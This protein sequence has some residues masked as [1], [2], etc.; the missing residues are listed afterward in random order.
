MLFIHKNNGYSSAFIRTRIWAYCIFCNA[1][2]FFSSFFF[3]FVEW[4][5]NSQEFHSSMEFTFAFLD[6]SW[7]FCRQM[8][9]EKYTTYNVPFS[10][11]LFPIF[12]CY[13]IYKS[14]MMFGFWIEILHHMKSS[15][16]SRQFFLY[17]HLVKRMQT[18]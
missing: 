12:Y 16:Q 10:R 18:S 17:I 15:I 8:N 4:N 6:H 1:I 7:L 14:S 13:N 9:S 11:T 3:N 5:L 2:Q